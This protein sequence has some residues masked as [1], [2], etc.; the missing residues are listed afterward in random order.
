MLYIKTLIICDE[1][2]NPIIKLEHIKAIDGLSKAI[3]IVKEK[4]GIGIKQKIKKK[5]SALDKEMIEYF[6]M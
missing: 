1:F 5:L 6:K 2:D 3:F 4:E